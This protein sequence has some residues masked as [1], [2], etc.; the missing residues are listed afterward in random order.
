MAARAALLLPLTLAACA[1]TPASSGLPHDH[2]LDSPIRQVNAVV[3]ARELDGA[4]WDAFDPLLSLGADFTEEWNSRALFLEGGLHYGRDKIHLDGESGDRVEA[5]VEVVELSAGLLLEWPRGETWLRP[6]AGAGGSVL[7]VQA[8]LEDDDSRST[9][10]ATF[11]FYW[12]VGVLVPVSFE[13]HVGVELRSLDAGRVSTE[14]ADADIDSLQ[15][16]I[17]FGASF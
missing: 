16:G 5:T 7:F 9:D 12:K 1:S 17:V 14:F 2:A 3:G 6:Y 11:G 4:P 13:S 8:E 15:I 10:D